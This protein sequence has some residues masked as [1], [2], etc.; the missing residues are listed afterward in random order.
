MT[1]G[2]A[3]AS[4][5]QNLCDATPE[6]GGEHVVFLGDLLAP[7]AGLQKRRTIWGDLGGWDPRKS[8]EMRRRGGEI[9]ESGA[10]VAIDGATRVRPPQ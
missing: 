3:N 1:R 6:T 4:K 2:P 10:S 7:A 9:R 8:P 5:D